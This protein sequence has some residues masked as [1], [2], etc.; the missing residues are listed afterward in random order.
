MWTV[1]YAFM[2]ISYLC[3]GAG[4]GFWIIFSRCAARA[5][6]PP[7]DDH[8]TTA[9]GHARHTVYLR[10]RPL[11]PSVVLVEKWGFEPW[12]VRTTADGLS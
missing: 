11:I 1:E 12:Q 4:F 2:A 8:V 9:A 3:L 6:A 5:T 10:C 7:C